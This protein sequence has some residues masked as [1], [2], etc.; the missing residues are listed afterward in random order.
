MKR[1]VLLITIFIIWLSQSGC[2]WMEYFTV[3][4]LSDSSIFVSYK[5]KPLSEDKTFGLFDTSPTF[6]KVSRK[7]GVHWDQKITIEDIDD[8]TEGVSIYLPAKT[9]MIFGRLRNDNYENSNQ[10][11]ING[12]E[13]NLDFLEVEVNLEVHHISKETF[14]KHFTKKNGYIKFDIE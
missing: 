2:S 10:Y 7:G 1:I 11:F 14:D 4:N 13:F 5:L 12:R 6:Y 3:G 8:S 9:V